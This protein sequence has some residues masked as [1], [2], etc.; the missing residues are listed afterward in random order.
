MNIVILGPQG[1]GKGTQAEKLVNKYKLA[2]VEMGEI[3]RGIVKEDTLLGNKVNEFI[4]VQ[5]KLVPDEIIFEVINN[6]LRNIGKFDGILFDGFPR[7]IS[8][9][10]YLDDFLKKKGKKIDLLIFL[11]LAREVSI[12]RLTSRRICEKCGA[13]FNLI[14][15]PPKQPFLCDLC[16]GK[17]IT[18]ADENPEKINVRLNEFEKHTVPMIEAY[19]R[20][21]IVEEVD[22]NR[23]IEP[24]FEDIVQRISKRGLS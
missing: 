20:K 3:L 24:I 22:G 19:R 16:D 18:R 7:I 1:S 8:Q 10:V 17:L 11:T 23:P 15:Q 14:T 13:I 5:G 12:K 4:N 9:A 6:H 2:Y 21:G